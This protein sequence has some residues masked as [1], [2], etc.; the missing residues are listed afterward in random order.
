MSKILG[1]IDNGMGNLF[2]LEN[3][4]VEKTNRTRYYINSENQLLPCD[5]LEFKNDIYLI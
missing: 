2:S 5:Y 3:T 1:I 4:K